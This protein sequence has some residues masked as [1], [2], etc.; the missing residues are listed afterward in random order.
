MARKFKTADYDAT[1]NITIR[2]G[3]AVPPNHLASFIVDII[4]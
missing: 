3:D 1:L 4:A 2:L